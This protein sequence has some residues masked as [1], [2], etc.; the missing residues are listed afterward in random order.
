MKDILWQLLLILIINK[1][2]IEANWVN[3]PYD[4]PFIHSSLCR[5]YFICINQIVKNVFLKTSFQ[6]SYMIHPN[7]DYMSKQFG[8]CHTHQ[9]YDMHMTSKLNCLVS[10]TIFF[11]AK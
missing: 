2:C 11:L 6:L 1:T 4:I 9:K 10:S 5:V 7:W 8:I 3:F